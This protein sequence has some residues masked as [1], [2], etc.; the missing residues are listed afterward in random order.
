MCDVI[1]VIFV[2]YKLHVLPQ[3]S[4]LVT[5]VSRTASIVL[6]FISIYADNNLK[7]I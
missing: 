6:L 4:S 1:N 3:T 2:A 5:Y 7:I